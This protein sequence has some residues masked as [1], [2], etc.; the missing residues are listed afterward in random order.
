MQILDLLSSE[1]ILRDVLAQTMTTWGLV[2]V[3]PWTELIWW[4]KSQKAY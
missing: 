3:C 4:T 2:D 1:K